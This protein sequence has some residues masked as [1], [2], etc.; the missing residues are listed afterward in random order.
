MNIEITSVAFT[1]GSRTD[2][3]AGLLGY[4]TCVLNDGLLQGH[5]A[6]AGRELSVREML[7]VSEQRI[8]TMFRGRPVAEAAVRSLV[9][10]AQLQ[11]GELD[12]AE[13]QVARTSGTESASFAG[14]GS[15]FCVVFIVMCPFV[16]GHRCAA[17]L[18]GD[19][20][21]S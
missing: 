17:P 5:D 18:I 20:V 4:V 9:G 13:A 1:R 11:L 21:W 7:E 3:R 12:R 15:G 6:V 16:G 19:R 2:I 8:E 14:V 10:C